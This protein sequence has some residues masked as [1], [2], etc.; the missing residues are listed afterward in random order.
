MIIKDGNKILVTL[1]NDVR[2]VR[3]IVLPSVYRTMFIMGRTHTKL[4]CGSM[5]K[6]H[7]I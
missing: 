7:A 3:M 1:W 6:L 2:K 5:R 4:T